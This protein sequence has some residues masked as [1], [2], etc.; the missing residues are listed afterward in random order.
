MKPL[1]KSYDHKAREKFWQEQWA[2]SDVYYFRDDKPREETFVI[3]TPPPTV[4]GVLHMGHIFS[5]TQADFVARYQRMSGKDVFYPMGFDDNGLPTERLV[6]KMREKKAAQYPSREAFVAD[7]REVVKSA[8]E[9]F[10]KLFRSAALSVDWRQ[11][12]QTISDEVRKLSQASFLDLLRRGEAY[13][14]FR[15]TYW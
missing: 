14:D 5:Y 7:C 1:P 6:E 15:P 2:K 9:E 12:Y 10:R 4:S 8:E 11:E 3:D 13:R